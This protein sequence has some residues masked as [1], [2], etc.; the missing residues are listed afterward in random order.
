M[1]I[2]NTKSAMDIVNPKFAETIACGAIPVCPVD[3]YEGLL[4]KDK[5][6]VEF[7]ICK[8]IEE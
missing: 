6:Y 2:G 3:F 7:K 5:H 1:F 8:N 4:E